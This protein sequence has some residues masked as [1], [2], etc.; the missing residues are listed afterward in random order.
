MLNFRIHDIYSLLS[1]GNIKL[2][3]LNSTIMGLA[4]LTVLNSTIKDVIDSTSKNE[5]I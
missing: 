2:A 4:Q 1:K 3:V 5:H